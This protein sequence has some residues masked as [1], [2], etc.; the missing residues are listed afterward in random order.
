MSRE[1]ALLEPWASRFTVFCHVWCIPMFC[2]HYTQGT[3]Y[4]THG[5]FSL[6]K[7]V[8]SFS[9]SKIWAKSA[10]YTQQNTVHRQKFPL[11]VLLGLSLYKWGLQILP[12]WLVWKT[13]S[14]LA[15]MEPLRWVGE[16][17]DGDIAVPLWLDGEAAVLLLVDTGLQELHCKGR[18]TRQKHSA[19]R[20]FSAGFSLRCGLCERPLCGN[21]C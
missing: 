8:H 2:A 4:Y 12:V 20:Q 19:G 16:E 17:A 11:L 9:P 6:M 13:L 7:N 3:H 21:G 18:L 14:W 10:H 1:S 15:R 5:M